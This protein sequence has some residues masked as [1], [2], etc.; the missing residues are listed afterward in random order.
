MASISLSFC[1]TSRRHWLRSA[2]Q[3]GRCKGRAVL[4]MA[5][6]INPSGVDWP[7][8][9]TSQSSDL[10]RGILQHVIAGQQPI[11]IPPRTT[12]SPTGFVN[13]TAYLL[14]LVPLRVNGEVVGLIEVYQRPHRGPATERGFLSYLLQTG[15]LAESYLMRDRLRQLAERREWS[16]QLEQFLS[17]IHRQLRV[18]ETAFAVVNESRRL[19]GMERVTLVLGT[20]RQCRVRAV[21]GL[22][23]VDRRA[24]QVRHLAHL[25]SRV[26]KGREPLW[27]ETNHDDLP[28]QIEQQWNR[29]VDI[30]HVRRCAI[31]PLYSPARQT[32]QREEHEPFGALIFEQ[33]LQAT[34]DDQ[35]VPRVTQL[36]HHGQ[37]ALHNALRH[38]Q[39]F[40]LPLWRALGSL[41]DAI[42]G[43]H[44]SKSLAGAMLLVASILARNQRGH[45]LLDSRA[46]KDPAG[47]ATHHFRSAKWR[48]H[49]GERKAWPDG[50]SG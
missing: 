48:G 7:T 47:L 4:R 5:A 49:T 37:L 22:D 17:H 46:W 32:E 39:I 29:Y 28:P 15:E 21:S 19:S 10:H 11:T 45:R 16:V 43:R 3:S 30:S 34:A 18:D 31:I 13:P 25:A 26:M 20:G 8:T 14:L 24:E 36:S 38:E 50:S 6:Q 40:L 27:L 1:V 44:F 41:C 35:Q 42:G 2:G 12:L 23:S 9:D 33:S